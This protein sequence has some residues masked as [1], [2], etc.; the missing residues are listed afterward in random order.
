[1][2]G[3]RSIV[4]RDGTAPTADAGR[5]GVQQIVQRERIAVASPLNQTAQR[6]WVGGVDHRPSLMDARFTSW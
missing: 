2:D 4:E 3:V 6:R 1:L 5:H